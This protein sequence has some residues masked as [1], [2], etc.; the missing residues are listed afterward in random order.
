[1]LRRLRESASLTQDELAERAGLTT[2]AIGALERGERRRPYPHT[3]RSLADALEADDG[4][5]AALADAASRSRA[6]KPATAPTTLIGR[7][8]DVADVLAALRTGAS[9]LITITGPGGVGKTDLALAVAGVWAAERGEQVAV[10]E[11]A[12]ITDVRLVV[13]TIAKALGLPQGEPAEL[14]DR[15][16]VFRTGRRALLVLDNVEH[17][18]DASA[19]IGELL[20]RCPTV[21]MLATS[22]APLRI[23]A[24]QERPLAPLSLPASSAL[25][26]VAAAPAVRM[27]VERARAVAP[28]FELTA[29]NCAAVEAI[30]R[31][32][33]GLP[34]AIELAAAHVR[35][36]EPRALVDRLD[37]ALGRPRARDVPARQAT[38]RA[39]LDWSYALLTADEQAMLRTLSV[40]S[41]TFTVEAVEAVAGSANVVAALAGLV[42]QSLVVPA[43]D[44]SSYRILEPVRQYA[45]AH[46]A[47]TGDTSE[48]AA[49]HA[50]YYVG[51]A[52]SARTGLR[53]RDQAGWL[54]RLQ[55][56]HGNLGAALATLIVTDPAAAGTLLADT[57][58][59]WALRGV[60]G[61][62][63]SWAERALRA[64]SA[65][66][67]LLALSGLHYA[68][69]DTAGTFEAG[70]DAVAVLAGSPYLGEGL[71]LY[72]AGAALIGDVDTA[73]RVTA[74]A[75]A[76]G[77]SSGDRWVL[78]HSLIAQSLL[79]LSTGDLA[80]GVATLAEADSV[81]RELGSPF[82]IATVLNV[83]ASLALLSD[84]DDDALVRLDEA[85][86]LAAEVGTNWS[87][88]YTLPD[89]AVVAAH[90][91]QW[92][93]AAT[94]FSAGAAL[95]AATSLG[96]A[97]GPDQQIAAACFADTKAHLDP[98]EFTRAWDEGREMR[99]EQVPDYVAMITRRSAPS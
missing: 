21:Q 50:A 88:V 25:A 64:E 61:E 80:A 76:E 34:L 81:A 35:L 24:E 36:L 20:A 1:M 27:F 84:D 74:Q 82:S 12:P 8:D 2:K 93:L 68:T 73:T 22:R 71:V 62:G 51:L 65:G 31:Q 75:L 66:P 7:D 90:R 48:V 13:P 87:L 11:L 79:V 47:A 23:R 99:A 54:D 30:C 26:V 58:P 14:L 52:S 57:W 53:G 91:G 89:L 94:L 63:V 46:L 42:E 32:L 19:E 33:D 29:A 85:A 3:V 92:V 15:L 16:A 40:F 41:G 56:E 67:A 45:A 37:Q 78:A 17:V 96:V 43:A 44:A 83:Q 86:Q 69:G 39:T 9:Q 60:A 10:A 98:D 49:R 72:G 55:S 95:S 59:Y 38:M 70:R 77:R 18:I 97:F 6:A 28:A 5:R 4:A